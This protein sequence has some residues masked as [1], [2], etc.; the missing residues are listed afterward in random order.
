VYDIGANVGLFSVRFA[1]WIGADGWLYAIEPNPMCVYLLRAN[2]V[3]A[4]V[5][6]FTILPVALSNHRAECA[7]TLNYGSTLIGVGGDSPYAGKPGHHIRVDAESL[8]ALIPALNLR[9]PNFIKLDV[10]G[11]EG[12]VVAGMMETIAT[13][14]PTLMIELHGREAASRT[15]KCLSGFD[16]RYLVSSTGEAFASAER[17]LDSLPEACVQVI[18]VPEQRQ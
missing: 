2:L 16:Y 4:R 9:G 11:A 8:D 10:E 1:R 3:D 14:R 15:L 7:F 17:L 6:N 13:T 12:T 5:E 18:G